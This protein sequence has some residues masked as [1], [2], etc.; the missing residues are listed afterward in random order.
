[1][2]CDAGARAMRLNGGKAVELEDML[3]ALWSLVVQPIIQTLGLHVTL[4]ALLHSI[5]L[6][7]M[8]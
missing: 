3:S 5:R 7:V 4:Y 1:M 8:F 2:A 6:I